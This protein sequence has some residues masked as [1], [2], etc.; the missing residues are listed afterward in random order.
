[1]QATRYRI[2]IYVGSKVIGDATQQI[3][4]RNDER[5]LSMNELDL[6]DMNPAATD[7]GGE[8]DSDDGEHGIVLT[9]LLILL[10][11]L[12][13]ALFTTDKWYSDGTRRSDKQIDT[14]GE[15]D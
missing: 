15:R 7:A 4:T 14:S 6:S 12:L 9:T 2:I 1:V 10:A 13:V 11:C 8:S 3:T 5:E